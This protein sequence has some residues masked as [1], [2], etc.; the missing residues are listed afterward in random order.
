[1]KTVIDE[2]GDLHVVQEAG[3]FAFE[4][5]RKD[6]LGAVEL[7]H[8]HTKKIH[9]EDVEDPVTVE[10]MQKLY[11]EKMEKIVLAENARD[12]IFKLS[13]LQD[14]I[15]SDLIKNMGCEFDSDE[16]LWDYVYN[17]GSFSKKLFVN[18]L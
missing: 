17:G 15:Y 11:I 2:Q 7:L 9:D 16:P 18:T 6:K 12:L 3:T 10:Y 13:E 8:T 1:M 14:Q 4:L 5:L